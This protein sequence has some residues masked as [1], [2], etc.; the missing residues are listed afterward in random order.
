MQSQTLSSTSS[1]YFGA[2]NSPS[3]FTLPTSLDN[4]Y[5]SWKC[6]VELCFK[7]ICLFQWHPSLIVAVVASYLQSFSVV[8]CRIS[9]ERNGYSISLDHLTNQM[10]RSFLSKS[11][12]LLQ[13]SQRSTGHSRSVSFSTLPWLWWNHWSVRWLAKTAR[14]FICNW[15]Q[16]SQLQLLATF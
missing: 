10:G 13:E 4:H 6:L 14:P 3:S 8:T 9:Q 1:L 7:A 2:K 5:I 15:G 12:W 11:F 16:V